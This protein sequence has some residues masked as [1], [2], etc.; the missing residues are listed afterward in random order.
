[1]EHSGDQPCE[2]KRAGADAD[3]DVRRADGGWAG[4]GGAAEDGR[5]GRTGGWRGG[6]DGNPALVFRA[7]AGR[8]ASL[9]SGGDAADDEASAAGAAGDGAA[10][11]GGAARRSANAIRARRGDVE[12]AIWGG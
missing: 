6:A 12:A 1:L 3:A 9:E 11:S 5:S 2:A 7:G 4:E 10:G 8:G